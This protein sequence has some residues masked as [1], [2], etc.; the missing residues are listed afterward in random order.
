MIWCGE[1]RTE[2]V[3]D[4]GGEIDVFKDVDDDAGDGLWDRLE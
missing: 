1:T 2:V 3:I 4:D